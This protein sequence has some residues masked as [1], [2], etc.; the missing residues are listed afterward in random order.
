MV[1]RR[2]IGE[3][4]VPAEAEGAVDQGLVTSDRGVG[5]HLEVGL[6]QLVFDL[7]AALPAPVAD[8]VDPHDLSQVRG[9]V[10]TVCLARAGTGW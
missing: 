1:L 4:G 8:A 5:A 6:A 3:P 9:R 10:G 7:F 2:V